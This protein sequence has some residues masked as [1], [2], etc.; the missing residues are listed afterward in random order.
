MPRF[1]DSI[2]VALMP[3][4]PY[5]N[6]RMF[7]RESRTVPS[8]CVVRSS[9]AFTSWRW[10]YPVS[11]VSRTTSP[12][13]RAKFRVLGTVISYILGYFSYPG[14][15]GRT[16]IAVISVIISL[17]TTFASLESIAGRASPTLIFAIR[18]SVYRPVTSL[19]TIS[20]FAAVTITERSLCVVTS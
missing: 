2:F 19:Y 1:A 16:S 12:F 7:M 8:Y 6:W 13:S 14:V 9:M 3:S 18:L 10:I 20:D 11:A 17:T 5:W 15:P 4:S